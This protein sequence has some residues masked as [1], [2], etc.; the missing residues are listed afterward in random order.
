MK[1]PGPRPYAPNCPNRLK[2][3]IDGIPRELEEAASID[4]C[5]WLQRFCHIVL[6][7]IGPGIVTLFSWNDFMFGL[8]LTTSRT[9]T[10]PVV[11]A[12]MLSGIGEGTASWGEV[13][14]A[15]VIQMLP[16]LIF[17]MMV[18]RQLLSKAIGSAVKG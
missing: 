13:F 7:L 5:S 11:L 1:R 9:Q 15:A 8:T 4:G 6:P 17:T 2:T 16:V 12:D 10:A 18:Q 14:A 3:F